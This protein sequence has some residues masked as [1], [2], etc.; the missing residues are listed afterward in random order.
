MNRILVLAV[1]V[2]AVSAWGQNS[3]SAQEPPDANKIFNQGVDL[4]RSGKTGEAI[5]LWLGILDDIDE[6]YR[7]N[8]HK[9]LSV[10]YRKQGSLPE[11][12]HHLA[13]YLRT[14]EGQDLKAGAL[15]EKVEGELAV[16]HQKIAVS[17]RPDGTSLHLSGAIAGVAYPC[18]LTWWFVAGKYSVLATADGFAS[19]TVE[20]DVLERGGQAL[21]EI[22]LEPTPDDGGGQIAGTANSQPSTGEQWTSS[23]HNGSGPGGIVKPAEPEGIPSGWKWGLVGGGATLLTTGLILQL[24]AYS[25]NEDL[26]DKYPMDVNSSDYASFK[27]S[28]ESGYADDVRPKAV[29][30]YVLY[31][32]G[33]AAAVAGVVLFIVDS[34]RQKSTAPTGVGVQPVVWRDGAGC[35]VSVGF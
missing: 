30:A 20:I 35:L 8:V 33:G 7:P 34:S 13:E 26:H 25:A 18:P 22:V 1:A 10:A 11:A 4:V 17:C 32:L 12:W 21:E 3:L 24:A 14:K 2:A 15:L 23:S 5:E 27:S 29:A 6:A 28:Y 9:A 16:D 19:R 31:G